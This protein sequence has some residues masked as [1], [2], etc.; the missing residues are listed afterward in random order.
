MQRN[1][2]KWRF[3]LSLSDAIGTIE[4]SNIIRKWT[5]IKTIR[6]TWTQRL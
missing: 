6:I 1:G 4:W 2:W 5:K 3:G